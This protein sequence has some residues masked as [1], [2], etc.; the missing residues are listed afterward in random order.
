MAA[1]ITTEPVYRDW[2]EILEQKVNLYKDATINGNTQLLAML[3]AQDE[4]SEIDHAATLYKDAKALGPHVL[5]DVNDTMNYLEDYIQGSNKDLKTSSEQLKNR[6][7]FLA[8]GDADK[9]DWE[10][11]LE[12][13]V[14]TE[15]KKSAEAWD[16][17][18]ERAKTKIKKLPQK[19]RAGASRVSLGAMSAVNDFAI[20][21][22]Q[23]LEGALDTVAQWLTQAWNKIKEWAV[24]TKNWFEGAW[25]TVKGW[26]GGGR[27]TRVNP[28]YFDCAAGKVWDP[29][30]NKEVILD[31]DGIAA[32]LQNTDLDKFFLIKKGGSWVAQLSR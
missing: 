13:N 22:R 14:E 30:C 23:W 20:K 9:G 7:D 19:V 2:E 26:F 27:V 29:I 6:W 16:G 8:Q 25:A 17:F 3:R 32:K 10:A 21:I 4:L 11:E 28:I 5:D 1:T 24:S 18:L 12:E 31:V 15:K